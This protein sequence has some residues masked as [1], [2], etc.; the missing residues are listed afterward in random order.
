MDQ[1]ALFAQ[2]EDAFH[3][4]G[5]ITVFLQSGDVVE[6]FLF[7]RAIGSDAKSEPPFVEILRK[8]TSE[9]VKISVSDC[10]RIEKTGEDCAAGKSYQ[11]WKVKQKVAANA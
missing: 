6:G 1:T 4:R 10:V 11:E 8:G 3:Y 7:N 2:I 5:H 9:R